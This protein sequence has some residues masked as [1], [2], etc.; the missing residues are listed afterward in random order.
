MKSGIKIQLETIG[1]GREA[2]RGDK[3]TI[4]YDLSLNRGDLIQSVDRY[5]FVLGKREVIAGL[6]YGVE[7]MRMGGHRQFRVRAHQSEV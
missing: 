6:E 4:R 2:T 5:S 3:V 7:G 1:T